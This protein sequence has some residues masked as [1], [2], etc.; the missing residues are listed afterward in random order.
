MPATEPLRV[1]IVGC[2]NISKPYA[3]TITA[4]TDTI[5]LLEINARISRSHAPLFQLVDGAPNHQIPIELVLG[6][7]PRF[8]RG[9]GAFRWAAKFM[10][11]VHEDAV[12]ERSPS[13]RVIERIRARYPD[14]RVRVLAPRGTQLSELV[15]QD[16]YSFE[17]A[18]IYIGANSRKALLAKGREVEAMLGFRLRR[19]TSEVA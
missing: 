11:R 19:I 18:E 4:H 2:G 9:N 14:V 1:A 15:F 5:R 8:P 12:V 10:L 13:A 16:S 6:Q 17:I 7:R 3:R